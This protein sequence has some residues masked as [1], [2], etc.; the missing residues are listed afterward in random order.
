MHLELVDNVSREL[1]SAILPAIEEAEEVRIAVAFIST[2]GIALIGSAL[3]QCLDRGGYAEFLVG[4]DLSTTEPQALWRLYE[5]SQ[6]HTGVEMYCYTDLGPSVVYHPKLYIMNAGEETTIVL[7]SSNLT[8]GGLRRNLEVNAVIRAHIQEEFVSDVHAV[9]NQLKFD[10]RRVVPDK[11]FLELYAQLCENQ[12]QQQRSAAR[13]RSSRQLKAA[14][15]EKAK[16]L[17][18]PTPTSRD[19]VGWLKLVYEHLPPGEFTN[20]QIYD[21]E[22]ELQQYYPDNLN[23][24]A[25]IRQQLQFLR[26]MGLIEHVAPARWRKV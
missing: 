25:K 20:H 19:L 18:R 13:D 5:L 11:E 15:R 26:D 7:G 8:G 23:V 12:K 17:R 24:R 14:F 16:T 9:Y 6:S 10:P 2:G 3:K 4:L 22:H 1:L 21:Y